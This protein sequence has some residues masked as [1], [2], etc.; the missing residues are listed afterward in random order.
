MS[1]AKCTSSTLEV[2]VRRI[3]QGSTDT[4]LIIQ[5]MHERNKYVLVLKCKF[6][7]CDIIMHVFDEFTIS[8]RIPHPSIDFHSVAWCM[9]WNAFSSKSI[10]KLYTGKISSSY[11]Q[12]CFNKADM[13]FVLDLFFL[14]LFCS[15]IKMT[16]T[17]SSILSSK[18]RH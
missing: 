11:T 10:Y 13:L 7:M 1:F 12:W 15:F 6:I 17:L 16:Y 18:T 8:F 4:R 14:N 5:S 3:L 2:K 9:M